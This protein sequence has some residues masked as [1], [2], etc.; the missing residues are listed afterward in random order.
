MGRANK[1]DARGHPGLN[2]GPLDLQSNTLPLSYTPTCEY[3]QTV[4]QTGAKRIRISRV[5]WVEQIKMTQGCTRV[6][7]GDLSICSRMLYH[8]A[9]PPRYMNAVSRESDCVHTTGFRFISPNHMTLYQNTHKLFPPI[10]L[11]PH[12]KLVKAC[13]QSSPKSSFWQKHDNPSKGFARIRR[14]NLI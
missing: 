4:Y 13:P 8:W 2:R 1:I 9:I 6:W 14:Y 5:I 12:I 10:G 3:L 11:H 7:T